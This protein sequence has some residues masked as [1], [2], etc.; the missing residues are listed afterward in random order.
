[1][2]TAPDALML[3]AAGLGTRM[4]DLTLHRPKPLIEVAGK[5][6]IDHALDLARAGGVTRIVANAHYH[7]AQIRAHLAG[8]GVVLSDESDVVLETGGGLRKA[9]PLLGP[10][11]VFTLN[12]DAVWTG[13]NVL[14]T[15]R[16]AWDPARMSALLALVPRAAALGYAG[17]GDFALLP[18]GRITRGEGY[19][20]TGAQ[21][22]DP[23]GIETISEPVFSLNLLWNRI[24]AEGRAYGVVHPGGWC[25]VGRPECIALAESLVRHDRH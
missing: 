23:A 25:D 8:T 11:P 6:L 2:R 20:Y 3:F 10:G 9:L 21:I 4:K 1:M 24:L 18:D 19:V 7:A 16:Q 15:L 13:P 5:P 14:A 12:S 22:L 17:A